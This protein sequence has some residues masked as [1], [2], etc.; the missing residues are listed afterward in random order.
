MSHPLRDPR[1]ACAALVLL[2]ATLSGCSL[3]H[4]GGA[5]GNPMDTMTVEQLYG[6]GADAL[7]F[8]N[9]DLATR[10]FT[11]LIARFPFGAYT[12][13]SQLNLAYAQYKNDKP[14]D[15]YSTINRFIK[16]YPTN[17]YADYAYY[18]R[19]L[20]NFDRSSG[21]LT[22]Y[23]GSD[24]TQRDL[25]FVRQSFDDFGSLVKRYPD[26]RYAVDGRQ[27][28]IYLRN[29]LAKSELNVAFYYLRRGAYVASA[30]R[31]KSIVETYPR[32]PEVGDALAIMIVSYD[33]LGQKKLAEG[34]ESVLKLNYPNHPFFAGGWPHYRSTWWKLLPLAARG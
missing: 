27:R 3:F 5:K 10:A 9:Y 8:G 4:R 14:D 32:A 28:M 23:V 7:K 31:A 12:E 30:N 6:Q 2:L 24:S 18:L 13:Q 17:Q 29:L 22:S 26:S 25:A 20:I 33:K 21:F 11:R 16:T 19:G 1:L 34:A 15:A